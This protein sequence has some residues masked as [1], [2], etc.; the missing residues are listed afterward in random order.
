MTTNAKK[1]NRILTASLIILIASLI[2]LIA[3]TSGANRKAKPPADE[4]PVGETWNGGRDREDE[5][6]A[7][8]KSPA[9]SD[10]NG[11]S[12]G[13]TAPSFAPA[14]GETEEDEGFDERLAPTAEMNSVEKT[15]DGKAGS[16]VGAGSEA[17][18]DTAAV[19]TSADL[20]DE[21]L[22][23]FRPPLENAVAVKGCSLAVPVFSATMDDYRTHGGI[24]F[25]CAPGTPVLAAAG[26][27]V[28]SV[29]KDPM[30]GWTVTLGHS[31]GAVT[32]YA[33]LS[34]ESA[35]ISKAGDKVLAGQVIGAS[36]ETALIESAEENHLHFELAVDG[37]AV[38]PA[39][40]MDVV[41][42]SDVTED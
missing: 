37:K 14:A 39:E 5:S 35:N 29:A 25:A 40:Y 12:D 15:P 19:P 36:G 8:A 33:G 18:R 38:D 27:T 10:D 26:G 4:P 9:P 11:K 1:Q 13:K 23:T 7:P 42:L 16:G 24:D 2:A 32:R 30:M 17:D 34:E 41:W 3:I 6:S 22:P 21:L 20:T 31:G 28:V